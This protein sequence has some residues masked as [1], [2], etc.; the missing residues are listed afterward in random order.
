MGAFGCG[1]GVFYFCPILGFIALGF[2]WLD[3]VFGGLLGLPLIG[4]RVIA[5]VFWYFGL[6]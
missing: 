1:V 6:V 4:L 5:L 3:L 2:G